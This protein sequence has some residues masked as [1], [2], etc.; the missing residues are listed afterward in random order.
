MR[1]IPIFFSDSR[2]PFLE[3]SSMDNTLLD[4]EVKFEDAFENNQ[5]P[6][7]LFDHKTAFQESLAG[8]Y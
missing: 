6:S 5:E 1:T 8:I 4:I 3:G 2:G 7:Y